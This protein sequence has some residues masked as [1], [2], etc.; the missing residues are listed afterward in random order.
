MTVTAEGRGW[1]TA[2]PSFLRIYHSTPHIVTGRNPYS[3]LFSGRKMCRKIP[4]FSSGDEDLDVRQR[5]VEAKSNM[6]TYADVNANAKKSNIQE[7]DLVLL[8]QEKRSKL[9]SPCETTQYCTW[10]L[11]RRGPWS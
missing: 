3:L 5:D 7:G 10:W 6:K 2:L 4:Q 11:R 1:K 8:R 9:S